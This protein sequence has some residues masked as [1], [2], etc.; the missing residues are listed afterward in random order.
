MGTTCA[1]PA[2]MILQV[3]STVVQ[4]DID[5]KITKSSAD[6]NLAVSVPKSSLFV[7]V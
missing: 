2:L 5:E 7:K 1:F 3:F 6:P 4:W